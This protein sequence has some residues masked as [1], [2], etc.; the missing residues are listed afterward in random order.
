[1]R[2]SQRYRHMVLGGLFLVEQPCLEIFPELLER[3]GGSE[4]QGEVVPGL[5]RQVGE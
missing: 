3:G 1:M 5:R 2:V 4:V